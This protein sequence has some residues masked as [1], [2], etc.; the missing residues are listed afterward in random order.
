MANGFK[1][2]EATCRNRCVRPQSAIYCERDMATVYNRM[3]Q[4]WAYT[5]GHGQVLMRS[6]KIDPAS[7]R[8]DIAFKNVI[9]L[10]LPSVFDRLAIEESSAD[11]IGL[12][13]SLTHRPQCLDSP[14]HLGR[15][16]L[17][18]LRRRW[19]NVH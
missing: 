10:K 14:R 19:R 7:S 2:S 4:L 16:S 11:Q 5:V 13:E 8:V 17:R 9:A 1:G 18:R 3:F 12:P 15:C 6:T